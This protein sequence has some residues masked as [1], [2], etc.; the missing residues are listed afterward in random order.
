M[1]KSILEMLMAFV[2]STPLKSR[3]TY[4]LIG[5]P[6]LVDS[7]IYISWCDYTSKDN[8][9]CTIE[10]Y[11]VAA[12]LQFVEPNNSGTIPPIYLMETPIK[13]WPKKQ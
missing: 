3:P 10:H 6:P 7:H 4:L 1:Y 5:Y 2:N 8:T 9:L 12:M 11:S 13:L